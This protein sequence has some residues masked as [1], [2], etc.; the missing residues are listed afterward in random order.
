MSKVTPSAKAKT[1]S[2]SNNR[3]S[4]GEPAVT[5]NFILDLGFLDVLGPQLVKL[6]KRK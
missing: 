1:P 3:D 5:F 6:P 2:G 4:N